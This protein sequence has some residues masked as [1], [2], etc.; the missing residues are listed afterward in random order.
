MPSEMLSSARLNRFGKALIFSV[1]L[2]TIAGFYTRQL[3]L[4]RGDFPAFYSAAVLAASGASAEELYSEDKQQAIQL[5]H[6]PEMKDEFLMFS[7]PASVAV[8][9]SPLFHAGGVT[10][11]YIFTAI[12]MFLG[13]VFLLQ[14][15]KPQPVAFPYFSA[16]LAISFLPFLSAVTSG[17]LSVFVFLALIAI[18]S[19]L[20][21]DI[22]ELRPSRLILPMLLL[23]FK[24]NILL[25]AVTAVFFLTSA[26]KRWLLLPLSLAVIFAHY[27]VGVVYFSWD[28][29]LA[30]FKATVLFAERDFVANGHLQSSAVDLASNLHYFL[31]GSGIEL[32]V[33]VPLSLL[34]IAFLARSYSEKIPVHLLFI[35]LV[36]LGTVHL[37]YYDLGI[38]SAMFW[39][40]APAESRKSVWFLLPW[41][42]INILI[43]VKDS[44]PF[45]PALILATAFFLVMHRKGL[46]A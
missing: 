10:A 26:S 3:H 2:A 19:E 4:V 25:T 18:A 39:L 24:P 33:A 6:W 38:L 28:W 42:A 29:P 37:V 41:A 31:I 20:R 21:N 7:Y 43:V 12:A 34:L 40:A 46:R 36:C 17:Q 32:V 8:V 15:A 30:W 16:G 35:L 13:A 27:M 44:L 23:G 1:F 22:A 9:L 11:K 14:C 45:Q 5:Q